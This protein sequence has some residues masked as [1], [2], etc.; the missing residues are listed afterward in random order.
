MN[1]PNPNCLVCDS[2]LR[3]VTYV[4]R[5]S[6]NGREIEV[7]NMEKYE[8]AGC[9][10]GPMFADQIKRNQLKVADAKRSAEG[11]LTS[12]EI[13]G[14]RNRLGLTQ[15]AAANI[16]R[17]G[18]NAFSKY[19]RGE[20]LQSFQMDR[21]LRLALDVP[22]VLHRLA[23]YSGEALPDTQFISNRGPS[24]WQ[25]GSAALRLRKVLNA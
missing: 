4:D 25:S 3:G 1:A 11:L 18:E 6:H 23:I 2:P 7:S 21:L 17:G 13:R 9:G 15:F 8:C 24:N 5:F 16:F 10:A 22:E 14:V 20:V 19:E 12:E